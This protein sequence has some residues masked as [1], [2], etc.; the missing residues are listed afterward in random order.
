MFRKILVAIDQGDTCANLF[1]QALTLAQATGAGLMLLSVLEPKYS[2]SFTTPAYY[3]YPLPLGVDS[4]LWLD[5]YREAES[6]GLERLRSFTDQ[7]IAAGVSAEFTQ[8]LGSPGHE[9]CALAKTWAADL[10]VVGS[11]GRK[12]F[13]ELFLGSVSSY[14][15]HHAPCSVLVVDAQTLSGETVKT[16]NLTTAKGQ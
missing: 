15:M 3:G 5:L 8:L 13:S 10:I 1:Q 14:V 9:I 2:S 11:H 16:A 7:A 12:G 4:D 6:K